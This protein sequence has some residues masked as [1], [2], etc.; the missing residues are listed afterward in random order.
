MFALIEDLAY[1]QFLYKVGLVKGVGAAPRDVP[2]RNLTTDPYY[3]RGF[4]GV[5]F[6]EDHP[7]SLAEIEI[8][9]WEGEAGGFVEQTSKG[10]TP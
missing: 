6:F 9:P 5:L 1:S 10:G 2:R 3:T 4:R 7:T 8:L